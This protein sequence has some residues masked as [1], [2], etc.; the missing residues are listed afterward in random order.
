MLISRVIKSIK[1]CT[2]SRRGNAIVE[3][4]LLLPATLAILLGSA[5]VARY[6][7]IKELILIATHSTGDFVSRALTLTEADVTAALQIAADSVAVKVDSGITTIVISNVHKAIGVDPIVAWRRARSQD[8]DT[9]GCSITGA[10]GALASLPESLIVD[11]GKS[12]I[13][14]EICHHFEADFF[15]SDVVFAAGLVATNIHH[16]AIYRPRF[17]DLKTL[18]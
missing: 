5:D 6:L 7:D 8:G 1:A 9:A 2:A 11:D 12:L 10:E 4:A 18:Y 13:V 3:T 16:R 14:V 17:G 15:V